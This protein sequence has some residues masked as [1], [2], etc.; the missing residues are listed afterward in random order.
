MVRRILITLLVCLLPLAAQTTTPKYTVVGW[1]DLGMHCMDGKD[2]SIYSILPPYN[3]FHAQVVNSSGKLVKSSTGI[4]LT[5]EAVADPTGSINKSSIG[6]TNFWDYAKPLFG[7]ALA[8]EAGL[9]GF[10]MPGTLNKPQ[11]MRFDSPYNWFT[12]EGV[13]ITPY[14]DKGVKNY[15]P[16]MRIVARDNSNRELARTEIVLPVSDELDCR[17][18][19]A[20]GSAASTAKP[21]PN[22]AF[23]TDPEKDYKTN[24]LMLHDQKNAGNPLYAM[25]LAKMGYNS[26]GLLATVN[27]NKRPVLCAGCHSSNALG[28][29]MAG[30]S[31]M[32]SA[33]HMRHA[34]VL[35]PVTSLALDSENNRDACYRCHPGSATKCL[36]GAMGNATAPDGTMLM[37][38]QSCH[39]KMSTVGN[40]ARVG[41]LQEPSCQSCHTGTALKNNGQI[42]YTSV[43][44]AS[45]LERKPLDLTFATNANVPA[46]GLNLYRFSKGHGG[47]QCEACHGPTHAEYP[48]SH[49]NDNLQ[50]LRLQSHTGTLVE[51][52]ACHATVPSTVN[53]GPHG[54]HP[55]GQSWVGRHGDLA[56]GSGSA[57]CRACHG[58]DYRGTVLSTAK[59]ARSF[60]TEWGTKKF[61]AGATIGCYSCHNGP[62]GD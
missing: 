17:G 48:S 11:A 22:W 25:A 9:T 42:R 40:P 59:A 30:V 31:S 12:G 8:P 24:V 45:G 34:N 18:C 19:H 38:C 27:T 1:N 62:R 26:A 7:S 14:D 57:Q 33:M 50:S 35:D 60:S 3:T 52:T 41:W 6:K 54:M 47:L 16:M 39:G 44:E 5:Y 61:A 2:Y 55:V 56:E 13:P 43:F 20:S 4:K 15:Y 53:G 32:T 23:L 28:T 51:C 46:S 21:T 49:V 29:T 10:L 58:T 36:R 37:Q